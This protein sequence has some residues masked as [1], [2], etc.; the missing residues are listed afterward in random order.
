MPVVA[1]LVIALGLRTS[2]ISPPGSRELLPV[3]LRRTGRFSRLPPGEWSER[4][5]RITS[6]NNPLDFDLD[7]TKNLTA[8]DDACLSV[9]SL[10]ERDGGESV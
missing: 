5:R 6:T 10:K 1:H 9:Y 8:G 7:V 2:A 4:R 3:S